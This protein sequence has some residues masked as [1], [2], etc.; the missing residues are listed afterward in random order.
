MSQII[1]QH[2][3]ILKQ[4]RWSGDTDGIT[5]VGVEALT[6]AIST[7]KGLRRFHLSSWGFDSDWADVNAGMAIARMIRANETLVQVDLE[8]TTVRDEGMAHI[9]RALQDNSTLRVFRA[10]ATN[11]GCSGEGTSSLS[12]EGGLAL[13][14]TIEVNKTLRVLQIRGEYSNRVVKAVEKS[15]R[16]NTTLRELGLSGSMSKKGWKYL[17]GKLQ[18]NETLESLIFRQLY[19]K[20]TDEFLCLPADMLVI[21]KNIRRLSFKGSGM[22]NNAASKTVS[23]SFLSGL[24]SNTTLHALDVRD[25]NIG[26]EGALVIASALV[27]NSSL[28]TLNLRG[29]SLGEAGVKALI[30]PLMNGH[31][32]TLRSL[33][34]SD[35]FP[36]TSADAV[37]ALAVL[38]QTS[39]LR[40]LVISGENVV[41]YAAGAFSAID[42]SRRL[43]RSS[44]SNLLLVRKKN[45]LEDKA[46]AGRRRRSQLII[47]V[48]YC[49]LRNNS[50]S[51]E[52]GTDLR[53]RVGLLE[54]ADRKR[55]ACYLV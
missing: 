21:N 11:F 9:L 28:Q 42:E 20:Y 52:V 23:A 51:S 22:A 29:N 26:I 32:T 44:S 46:P 17:I 25:S 43:P 30:H 36:D 1:V 31:N 49:F 54:T 10:G 41:L 34:I 16:S 18:Q 19:A 33:D 14:K 50:W 38:L 35:S 48:L 47:P 4:N 40:F 55:K 53:K 3:C 2:N 24:V 13:A 15:L 39:R 12:H 37:T 45:K 6:K 27:A 5:H 8:C 7:H